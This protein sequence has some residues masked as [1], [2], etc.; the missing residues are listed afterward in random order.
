LQDKYKNREEFIYEA[1]HPEEGILVVGEVVSENQ[2][3]VNGALS[4]VKM[5]L[6]KTWIKTQC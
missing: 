3:W 6:S 4:S 1:Q 2:G 5:V